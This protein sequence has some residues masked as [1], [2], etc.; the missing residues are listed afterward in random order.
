MAAARSRPS[1]RR[2]CRQERRQADGR[3]LV[4][5]CG[6]RAGGFPVPAVAARCAAIRR[7]HAAR[8]GHRPRR[9][10]DRRPVGI[11][12]GVLRL[13]GRRTVGVA[14]GERRRHDRPLA[15][16]D[17]RV[18]RTAEPRGIPDLHRGDLDLDQCHQLQRRGGWAVGQPERGLARV[19]GLPA[20]WRRR[21]QGDGGLPADSLRSA[22]RAMGEPRHHHG[23]RGGRL[24]LAQ[25]P[26]QQRAD[27]P[28]PDRGHWGC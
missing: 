26:A 17:Q 18:V 5:R 19:P 6:V 3:R 7:R 13:P 8:L 16:A 4:L 1:L 2:G 20:L 23:W 21:R 11:P 28:M 25:R 12:A 10:R 9:R 15:A 22:N 14:A 24:S 27:G